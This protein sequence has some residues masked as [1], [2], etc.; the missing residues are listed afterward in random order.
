[1]KLK[2]RLEINV[3]VFALYYILLLYDLF[4]IYFSAFYFQMIIF[5]SL[6]FVH[7]TIDGT[8]YLN[9]LKIKNLLHNQPMTTNPCN[10]LYWYPRPV[11]AYCQLQK[12]PN[13]IKVKVEPKPMPIPVPLPSHPIAS[14]GTA[15]MFYPPIIFPPSTFSSPIVPPQPIFPVIEQ[16]LLLQSLIG[17]F[18]DPMPSLAH[19]TGMVPGLP[20]LV[21]R[22]GGINILPFSDAYSDL[23]E[24]HKQKMIRKKLY[25]ILKRYEDYPRSSRLG[26]R[27]RFRH[28][29]YE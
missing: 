9:E 1:M 26:R 2:T 15:S 3:S 23:L 18:Q 22:D 12:A 6:K 11:P 21:T 17:G 10:S 14:P 25:K 29:L 16:N 7:C 19:G 4:L 24:K 13:S 28:V 20:G 8:S 27:K 5:F